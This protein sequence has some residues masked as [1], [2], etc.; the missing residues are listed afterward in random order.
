MKTKIYC[1]TQEKGVHTFYLNHG[2]EVYYLFAQDYRK[3]V[4]KYYGCPIS[5]DEAID[6]SRAKRDNAIL[7]TMEKIMAS[8]RYLEKQY[9]IAIYKK[10]IKKIRTLADRRACA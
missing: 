7:R 1:K 4:N 6:Y 10:S 3:G 2:G 5:F 9:N 8:V